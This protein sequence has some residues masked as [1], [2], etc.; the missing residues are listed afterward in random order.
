M[1][2]ATVY[3]HPAL[4]SLGD[5]LLR[6]R[7]VAELACKNVYVW[8]FD[9]E[10]KRV[11]VAFVGD[12]LDLQLRAVQAM[13]R[14]RDYHLDVSLQQALG[15]LGPGG[16]YGRR[17]GAPPHQ[18]MS[19]PDAHIEEV[20]SAVE[21]YAKDFLGALGVSCNVDATLMPTEGRP[22]SERWA[23]LPTPWY[24]ARR[25]SPMLTPRPPWTVEVDTVESGR[26]LGADLCQLFPV[27]DSCDPSLAASIPGA[28]VFLLTHSLDPERHA[29]VASA[30]KACR[31]LLF[32]SL[33]F[34]DVPAT[35]FGPLVLVCSPSVAL[36]G[37]KP[38]AKRGG[39]W[40]VICYD[41]DAWTSRGSDYLVDGSVELF[42]DLTGA[43][44]NWIF[45]HHEWILGPPV[46]EGS[47]MATP[48]RIERTKR[49]AT[50]LHSLARLYPRRLGAEDLSVLSEAANDRYPYVECKSHLIVSPECFTLA[51]APKRLR[52]EATAFL[53]KAGFKVELV[54]IDADPEAPATGRHG[55]WDYGWAV[56]DVVLALAERRKAVLDVLVE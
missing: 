55:S 41:T 44:Q 34:G 54:L 27:I 39:R 11:G 2:H 33:A 20:L 31:G 8:P 6:W 17:E 23:D 50:R 26:K 36:A 53:R 37:M 14:N 5:A 56:R 13:I 42:A 3:L 28:G 46:A 43:P 32:P 47:G 49:L 35:P 9:P 10:M 22:W 16:R 15:L 24:D 25:R 38:Y 12:A 40:G 48:R 7:G 29:E 45:K 4:A 52:K 18:H 30:V 19:E 1:A 51:V 21:K